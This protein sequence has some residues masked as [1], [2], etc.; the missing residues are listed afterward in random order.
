MN[1]TEK[2]LTWK[3]V[4]S[5]RSDSYFVCDQEPT[6]HV[7]KQR[8]QGRGMRGAIGVRWIR[9]RVVNDALV[10]SEEFK[11]KTDAMDVSIL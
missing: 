4:A 9:V 10:S 3:K 2:K 7:Y 1:L 8:A 11:T 6:L 5:Q